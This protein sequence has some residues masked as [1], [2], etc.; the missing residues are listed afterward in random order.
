MEFTYDSYRSLLSLLAQHGYQTADYHNWKDKKRCAIL[1][2]DIDCSIEAALKFAELEKDCGVKSTYFI[3]TSSDFY[4]A[5]S[6]KN[7]NLIHKIQNAGHEI[8]LHFDEIAYP[9]SIGNI[10]CIKEKILQ[11]AH[12]LQDV[13]GTP[14]TIV[15]M[16]RPSEAILNS[17]LQIPEIINTYSKPYFKECKYLSDSRHH[18]REPVEKIIKN[19]DYE[20]LQI[21]V[22][23]FWY[24]AEN[25][26]ADNTLKEFIEAGKE[27]RAAA[28]GENIRDIDSLLN[29]SE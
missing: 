21:L 23:P 4:N 11:E 5:F 17:N 22:H 8:G 20:R 18:W 9:D 26:K 12:L 10:V 28:L 24:H 2:H 3:L 29:E 1:R 25:K 13:M 19:E 15:S 16:H 6:K 14:V 27:E 7:R